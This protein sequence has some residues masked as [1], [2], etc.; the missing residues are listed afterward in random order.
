[1]LC[2]HPSVNAVATL[3]A[4]IM[5]DACF[6]PKEHKETGETKTR[7][8]NL[9]VTAEKGRVTRVR[10]YCSTSELTSGSFHR[11]KKIILPYFYSTYHALT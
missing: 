1:M 9:H 2:G 5:S 10:R 8:Q 4:H 3:G 6:S 11:V 7:G